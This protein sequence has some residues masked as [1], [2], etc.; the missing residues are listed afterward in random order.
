M[1]V[2]SLGTF[3][4]SCADCLRLWL[5][6]GGVL[7][8]TAIQGTRSNRDLT[9]YLLLAGMRT[10]YATILAFCAFLCGWGAARFLVSPGPDVRPERVSHLRDEH[11]STSEISDA[12]VNSS[13]KREAVAAPHKE[14]QPRSAAELADSI[15]NAIVNPDKLRKQRA[16]LDLL[17]YFPPENAPTIRDVFLAFS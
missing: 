7:V 13:N 9:R 12:P 14:S 2:M 8:T 4:A 15:R 16:V 17:A 1:C 3:S 10:S 6:S 5:L 11:S